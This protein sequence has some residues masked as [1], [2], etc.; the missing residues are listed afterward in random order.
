MDVKSLQM[1]YEWMS[2]NKNKSNF[3]TIGG[4]I[5]SGRSMEIYWQI[6]AACFI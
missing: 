1:N 6:V 4:K 3:S 5:N 2:Q